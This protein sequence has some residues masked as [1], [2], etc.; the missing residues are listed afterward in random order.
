MLLRHQEAEIADLERRD[1]EARQVFDTLEAD[2]RALKEKVGRREH[3]ALLAEHEVGFLQAL[4]VCILHFT[5][6]CHE[7]LI[8]F[9]VQRRASTLKNKLNKVIP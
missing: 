6:V 9:N 1:A 2:V 8:P 7:N 5:L 4:L 3:R